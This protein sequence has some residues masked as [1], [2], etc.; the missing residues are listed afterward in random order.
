MKRLAA[1]FGVATVV[2]GAGVFYFSARLAAPAPSA[3]GLP[4]RD[5]AAESVAFQSDSGSKLRGWFILGEPGHPA[6]VLMHGIRAN[7]LSMISRARFLR[8]A[9]YSVLLFD[10]QAHGESPGAHITFG[11]LEAY[12]A[13]AALKFVHGRLPGIPVGAI[14]TSLGGAAALLGPQPLSVHALV[15]EAVYPSIEAAVGNRIAIRFG[16]AGRLLAPLMLLQLQP[17]LGLDPAELEPIR[18]ISEVGCPVLVIAGRSDAHTTLADSK[19]L[20]SAAHEPKGLWVVDAAAHVDFH[21]FAGAEYERRILDFFK[22]NL[23][24]GAS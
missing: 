11:H 15:L 19:E 17:R 5:L 18:Q 1:L 21:R 22:H 13:R 2:L 10:F 6:I 14:G 7:R 24:P 3:V 12:D 9:G 20:F 4:P 8:A 23:S 16:R